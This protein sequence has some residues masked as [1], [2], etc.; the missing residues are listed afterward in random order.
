LDILSTIARHF[1]HKGHITDI[2]EYGSGNINDTYLITLDSPQHG[3]IILQRINQNVFPSPEWIMRNMRTFLEHLDAR[4]RREVSDDGRRWEMPRIVPTEAGED[5]FVDGAGEFWRALTFIEGAQTYPYIRNPAHARE[6]GYAL[7]KFHSLISDLEPD[8]LYDTL[9]GF[10]IMPQYLRHY[11][12]VLAQPRVSL[13]GADVVYCLHVVDEAREWGVLLEDALAAGKLRLQAIHGDPK[14]DNI[15]IDP[16][17]GQAVSLIDLDTVKPG[18]IHYDIGDCLRSGCNPLGE[19]PDDID[20]V[21]FDTDLCRA[22]LE[23]YL[24]EARRF[25]TA[26][27]YAYLY[28]SVRRLAFEMGLRFFTDYLEGDVYFKVRDEGHNLLRAVV[29]FRLLESIE[30]C[31]TDIRTIIDDLK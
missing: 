13:T 4:L 24:P 18:L 23:G 15:M 14:V 1:A 16:A 26:N 10:H 25:L 22:I 7:G 30:A 2:R 17:T 3:K 31:A 20:G 27:D 11:D 19:E 28:D 9:K 12:E 5:Y 21:R 29:Q 6:V 8:K